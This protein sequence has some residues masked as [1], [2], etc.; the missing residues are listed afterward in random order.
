M[1]RG[2][3]YADFHEHYC[4]LRKFC[5]I[6]LY[7]F[8]PNRVK[9]HLLLRDNVAF[10]VHIFRELRIIQRIYAEIFSTEYHENPSRNIEITGINS[11][12]LSSVTIPELIF[13][14]FTLAR[15][16]SVRNYNTE[17]HINPTKLWSLVRGPTRTD[18]RTVVVST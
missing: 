13:T 9:I 1:K 15:Q 6:L 7:H 10:T 4:R 17:F 2:L 5:G 18:R 3:N 12:T 11:F 14:K 8:H 16:L